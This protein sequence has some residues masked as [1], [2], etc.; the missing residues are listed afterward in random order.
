LDENDRTEIYNTLDTLAANSIQLHELNEVIQLIND[1]MM[2][3]KES[4]D[5][6]NKIEKF[7]YELLQFT[8][9]IEDLEMG[10]QLSRLG[11][12]N[13][14]LLN[15]DKLDNVNSQNIP[16]IKTSTWLNAQEY[17]ILI[18]SHIPTHQQSLNTIKIIP[19]PDS[20]Q[21]QLEHTY[22]HSYFEKDGNIYNN[23]WFYFC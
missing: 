16:S 9:Y 23:V 3:I 17:L 20:H 19:Y 10:M 8:E 4:D 18:I 7:I 5:E 15:Y 1:R 22:T 21:Y 12:F 6:H 2:K 11:L 13:P 14:K